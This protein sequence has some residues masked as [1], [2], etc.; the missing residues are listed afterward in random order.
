[1]PLTQADFFETLVAPLPLYREPVQR[2]WSAYHCSSATG[3]PRLACLALLQA[4][5]ELKTEGFDGPR[6]LQ[7]R[8]DPLTSLSNGSDFIAPW[9]FEVIA[10]AFPLFIENEIGN[11]SY[12]GGDDPKFFYLKAKEGRPALASQRF[13]GKLTQLGAQW[14]P[15]VPID[16]ELIT[17]L[18][19][20]VAFQH[21]TLSAKALLANAGSSLTYGTQIP[22]GM[23]AE[24]WRDYFATYLQALDNQVFKKRNGVS[25]HIMVGPWASL[26]LAKSYSSAFVALTL[27]L[28]DQYAGISTCD[29]RLKGQK[30]KLLKAN[31]LCGEDANK[32]VLFRSGSEWSDAALSWGIK[33]MYWEDGKLRSMED[34]LAVPHSIAVLHIKDEPGQL[35]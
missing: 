15:E 23:Q 18:A 26:F 9:L 5:A 6:S 27:G 7:A 17:A 10:R 33:S 2:A 19:R 20:E 28:E 8:L 30:L 25:T 11:I 12:M 35:L 3:S 21:N 32:V 22:E 24:E 13:F 31:F 16:D 4:M 14:S 34:R 1:M 29:I